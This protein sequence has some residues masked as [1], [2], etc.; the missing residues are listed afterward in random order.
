MIIVYTCQEDLSFSVFR[1]SA[2]RWLISSRSS[3]KLLAPVVYSKT[4]SFQGDS[5]LAFYINSFI[6]QILPFLSS[7]KN[8][9]DF[10][11]YF[12]KSKKN[13]KIMI[14]FFAKLFHDQPDTCPGV[15]WYFNPIGSAVFMFFEYNK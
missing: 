3:S 4:L 11:R 14:F 5:R 2:I 15:M 10:S 7:C 12:H 8:L 1:S 6:V 9:A 13:S